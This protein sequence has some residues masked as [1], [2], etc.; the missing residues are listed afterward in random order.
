MS[1]R[2]PKKEA[3]RQNKQSASPE[4]IHDEDMKQ[5]KPKSAIKGIE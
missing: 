4:V 2:E 3:K 1:H 5:K